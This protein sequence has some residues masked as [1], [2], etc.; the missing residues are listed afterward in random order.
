MRTAVLLLCLLALSAI[1]GSV[2]PQRGVASNPSSVPQFVSAHPEISPWLERLGLFDVYA[3]PWFA[4]IYLLLLVS[5]TGC[6][7]PRSL[8]L[9]RAARAAPP[10]SPTN[11]SRLEAFRTIE[12]EAAAVPTAIAQVQHEL[13]S[14]GFRVVAGSEEVR[15]EKGYLR[16]IG[17][18]A[19]HLSLLLL[20]VGVAYGK[21]VGFEGRVV[22]VEGGT[23]ANTESQYDAFHPAA[24]T[25]VGGLTPF[26]LRLDDLAV[27]YESTG[28]QRGQPRRFDATVTIDD[29]EGART[30]VASPNNPVEIDGT[31]VFLTGNGYAPVISVRDAAGD[32]VTSG[33]V[34]F[35]PDD[36]SNASTGVIK[37][38]DASPTGLGFEGVF[39]PTAA[40]GP[41][42]PYSAFPDVLNPQLFLTAYQG[43]LGIEAPQSVFTLDKTRLTPLNGGKPLTL[44][45]GETVEL[46]GGAG[47]VTFD[48]VVRFANFQIAYDPGKE[49]A[50]AAAILLL[51]GLTM[52]L[53]LP[54][55]RWWMRVRPAGPDRVT[56]EVGG[57]SLTQRELP[58]RDRILL[59]D[60]V[61]SFPA[62]VRQPTTGRIAR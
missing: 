14:R 52:S 35:L 58:S 55:R 41:S 33:P 53:T 22:V 50:L 1:P 28:L 27:D 60:L 39:L 20:L 43:D 48:E 61:G 18:L 59:D 9:W 17:N 42:G 32:V 8:R 19:F 31:K 49:I 13:R 23:F 54:R 6:V 26:T 51:T 37:V 45:P 46:P 24:L 21:L 44:A 47:S 34:V 5:M 16:E 29:P 56:V 10:S 7:L 38:P 25:D 36:L 30:D 62:A 3:A 57:L 40:S 2:L 15:A 4:A 11:M 12:I